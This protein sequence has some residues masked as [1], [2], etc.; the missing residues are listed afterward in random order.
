MSLGSRKLV[1][2]SGLSA[3]LLTGTAFSQT[4]VDCPCVGGAVRMSAT[5]INATLNGNTVCAI[6]GN[7]KWQEWHNGSAIVELGNSQ[8]GDTVGSWSAT[9]TSDSD[10][11]ITYSYTG[12]GSNTYSMCSQ[13]GVYHFCG[14]TN[15]TQATVNAGKVKCY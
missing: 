4:P 11:T 1:L 14:A 8:D 9:G 13:N 5:Q 10:S 15:V 3:T 12:A 2:I 6:V 7:D